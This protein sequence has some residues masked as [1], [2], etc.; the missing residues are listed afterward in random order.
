MPLRAVTAAVGRDSGEGNERSSWWSKRSSSRLAKAEKQRGF[1]NE[2]RCWW[3]WWRSSG[4]TQSSESERLMES[5]AAEVD[6]EGA[7]GADVISM[8]ELHEGAGLKVKPP[9]WLTLLC[10]EL[11]GN[12]GE[13]LAL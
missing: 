8:R 7:G 3:W 12:G 10:E 6:N 1:S 9:S 11:R 2:K 4:A 13:L 5:I